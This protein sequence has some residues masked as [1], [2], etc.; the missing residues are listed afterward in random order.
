MTLL[1]KRCGTEKE[2]NQINF[3]SY[4]YKEKT[5]L[6]KTCR[7]CCNEDTAA[8]QIKHRQRKAGQ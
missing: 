8:R 5:F 1:C 2:F 3:I 6:R 7:A 4:G